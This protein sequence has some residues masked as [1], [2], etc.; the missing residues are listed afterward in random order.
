VGSDPA[1]AEWRDR[2]IVAKPAEAKTI[3]SAVAGLLRRAS[4]GLN[5]GARVRA[6]ERI[7]ERS[8]CVPIYTF[9]LQDGERVYEIPF[10]RVD[11]TLDHLLSPLRMRIEASCESIRWAK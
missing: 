9:E 3:V 8:V 11:P 4:A 6:G 2:K 7:I 5:Y 1:I 10:A